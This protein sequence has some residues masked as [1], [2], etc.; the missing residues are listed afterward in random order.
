MAQKEDELNKAKHDL[1]VKKGVLKELQDRVSELTTERAELELEIGEI[2][3]EFEESLEQG[4]HLTTAVE[5]GELIATLNPGVIIGAITKE[6]ALAILK[7]V[8]EAKIDEYTKPVQ[9]EIDGIT[10]TIE[11]YEDMIVDTHAEIDQL[12]LD[13]TDLESDIYDLKDLLKDLDADIKAK[14][15][16]LN[17]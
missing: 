2:K 12:I 3:D 6:A 14:E 10:A 5:I 15:D 8:V 13:I 11:L 4:S 17:S 9:D 16:C 1:D 7:E